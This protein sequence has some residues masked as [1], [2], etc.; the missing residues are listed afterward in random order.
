LDITP[1]IMRGENSLYHAILVVDKGSSLALY[2]WSYRSM[3]FRTDV[4]SGDDTARWPILCK[5]GS[6][7]LGRPLG[8]TNDIVFLRGDTRW[9]VGNDYEPSVVYGNYLM[10]FRAVEPEF[11]PLSGKEISPYGNAYWS[12]LV[13][14]GDEE[15]ERTRQ[16]LEGSLTSDTYRK[17]GYE[18]VPE[19]DPEGALVAVAA[20]MPPTDKNPRSCQNRFIRDGMTFSFRHEPMPKK[21]W[22]RL[23][24]KLFER[25]RSFENSR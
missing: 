14:I 10:G 11:R 3:S 5:T 8:N 20:C 18:V 9:A 17:P 4:R 12:I 15:I 16:W 6:R 13:G 1:I 19:R 7:L 22:L 21:D 24:Q 2:N 23:Q 25:V